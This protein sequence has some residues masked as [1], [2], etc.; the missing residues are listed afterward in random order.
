MNRVLE[1]D[2]EVTIPRTEQPS[3]RT[4]F[5]VVPTTH[6]IGH[7]ALESPQQAN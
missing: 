4:K 2:T 1:A 7:L 5:D 6:I 3:K